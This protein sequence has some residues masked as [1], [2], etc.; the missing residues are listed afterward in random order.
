MELSTIV[1]K[2]VLPF[3]ETTYI[4]H[5]CGKPHLSSILRLSHPQRSQGSLF[6]LS[7]RGTFLF[8]LNKR[9]VTETTPT[10]QQ[11][12]KDSLPSFPSFSFPVFPVPLSTLVTLPSSDSWLCLPS[13][14]SFS[15]P[16]YL[17]ILILISLWKTYKWVTRRYDTY[18]GQWWLR[19]NFSL[20]EC[21]RDTLTHR[22]PLTLL[23]YN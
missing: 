9:Q 2:K 5:L 17:Q 21:L 10:D 15:S 22:T 11:T 3:T 6:Y 14:H 13:G 12:N 1:L 23:L 4:I 7:A 8:S 19:S 20:C 18:Q 16:T